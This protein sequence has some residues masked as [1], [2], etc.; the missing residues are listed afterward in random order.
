[1]RGKAPHFIG[2]E[3]FSGRGKPTFLIVRWFKSKISVDIILSMIPI[4]IL[5]PVY[6]GWEY[7]DECIE[8]ILQQTYISW[9]VIIGVN[10]HGDNSNSVYQTLNEK[11]QMINDSRIKIINIQ[12]IKGAPSVINYLG[13]LADTEWIAHIDVDDKWHPLKLEAQVL[14]IENEAVSCGII[15]TF[16]QYFGDWDGRPDQPGGRLSKEHFMKANPMIHSSIMIRKELV[17]YTDEFF[18]TYD[19]D[20][21]CKNIINGTNFFNVPYPLTYHRLHNG[22]VYNASGK[23]AP[24]LIRQKYF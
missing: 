7:F 18:G 11:V 10:G 6:N 17:H 9:R 24:D 23:Q 2:V 1:M 21:W 8:S 13:T 14:A 16:A 4:T 3:K 19:Y 20:C 15:G 5:I 22:S 12:E